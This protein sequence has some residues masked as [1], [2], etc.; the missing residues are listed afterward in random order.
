MYHGVF[1]SPVR[2]HP[3]TSRPSPHGSSSL[4]IRPN[5]RGS[6]RGSVYASLLDAL[7]DH[8]LVFEDARERSDS[9][10][11]FVVWEA[12]YAP[13]GLPQHEHSRW[14]R[15]PQHEHS[16]CA[17]LK[18]SQKIHAPVLLGDCFIET[19]CQLFGYLD[20]LSGDCDVPEGLFDIVR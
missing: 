2:V 20:K 9:P 6:R 13:G 5:F 17:P 15:L 16:R 1:A 18:R 8:V 19:M 14:R 7:E 10:Y 3:P 12:G 11:V 4:W